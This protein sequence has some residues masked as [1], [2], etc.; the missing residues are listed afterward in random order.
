MKIKNDSGEMVDLDFS[1]LQ[2]DADGKA[3]S[4]EQKEIIAALFESGSMD[5][6]SSD[7]LEKIKNISARLGHGEIPEL[8]KA[9]IVRFD[10]SWVSI[11]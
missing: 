10:L 4:D 11:K 8:A 5:A 7:Q 6:L 9:I 3:P 1:K 2:L